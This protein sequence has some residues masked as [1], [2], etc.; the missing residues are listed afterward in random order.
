[1]RWESETHA[2]TSEVCGERK[3]FGGKDFGGKIPQI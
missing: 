3:D 1:M 2:Q